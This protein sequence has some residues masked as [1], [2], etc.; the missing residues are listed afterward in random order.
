[1]CLTIEAMNYFLLKPLVLLT[2]EQFFFASI[3]EE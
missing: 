2:T 3:A 1:M